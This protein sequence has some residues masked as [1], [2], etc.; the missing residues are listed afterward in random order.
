MPKY[1]VETPASGVATNPDRKKA[2]AAYLRK[3]TVPSGQGFYIVRKPL[4]VYK[5]AWSGGKRA[6]VN[7]IIPEGA[8]VYCPSPDG[9][10]E[11]SRKCRASNAVVRSV[12]RAS[13]ERLSSGRHYA[14]EEVDSAV[15]SYYNSFWYS[16]GAKVYPAMGFCLNPESC[17]SGIHFF[18]DYVDAIHY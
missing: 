16:K 6:I 10:S 13:G 2:V 4:H 17:A 1:Y 5:Q 14:W 15:S 9:D 8:S 3:H 11:A 18:F 12:W 7:L